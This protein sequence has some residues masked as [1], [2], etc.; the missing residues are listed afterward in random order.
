MKIKKKQVSRLSQIFLDLCWSFDS[1]FPLIRFLSIPSEKWWFS[2]KIIKNVRLLTLFWQDRKSHIFHFQFFHFSS[3]LHIL[4][5]YKLYIW[6]PLT[7]LGNCSS[8]CWWLKTA[9]FCR[10]LVWHFHN[11][12]LELS[13]RQNPQHK[14]LFQS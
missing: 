3:N 4:F 1:L 11:H 12:F 13:R 8:G 6:D 10:I 14:Q 5:P 7:W 9:F 2:K